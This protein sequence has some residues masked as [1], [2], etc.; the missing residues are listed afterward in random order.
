MRLRIRAMPRHGKRPPQKNEGRRSAGRRN[1]F[2]AASRQRM[3]PF[4][5]AADAAAGLSASPLASRRSTAV[6]VAA[7]ERFDSAQAALHANGRAR[8]LPT[9][10][11]PSWASSYYVTVSDTNVNRTV[12]PF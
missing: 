3:L 6:L 12:T 5:D 4:A 8:A 7:T 11:A 9:P 1:V 10:H 2:G